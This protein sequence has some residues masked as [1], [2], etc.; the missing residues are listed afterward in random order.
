MV[1][2][3]LILMEGGWKSKL[4]LVLALLYCR[5]SFMNRYF[6]IFLKKAIN[7]S[8][9]IIVIEDFLNPIMLLFKS[10]FEIYCRE[11][12]F[13]NHWKIPRSNNQSLL[14]EF[15]KTFSLMNKR[16]SK[17]EESAVLYIS[18]YFIYIIFEAILYMLFTALI[19]I[20]RVSIYQ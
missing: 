1:W 11:L 9:Q 19:S 13:S 5:E 2:H 18:T 15:T 6:K 12:Y 3:H 16:Q 4:N 14:W 10:I 20:N 17:V 7:V 8:R